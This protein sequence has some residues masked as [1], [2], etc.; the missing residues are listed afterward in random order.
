MPMNPL[1]TPVRRIELVVGS[2]FAVRV[3]VSGW[4]TRAASDDG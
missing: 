4:G 3:D 1:V 2:G